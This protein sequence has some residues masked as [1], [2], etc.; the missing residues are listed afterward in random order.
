MKNNYYAVEFS[1]VVTPE[2][3][4][5]RL[6]VTL[7]YIGLP[8]KISRKMTES[9]IINAVELYHHDLDYDMSGAKVQEWF[10]RQV[11]KAACVYIKDPH[12]N[13]VVLTTRRSDGTKPLTFG[14]PGGKV[15]PGE[16]PLQA[17]LR[18]TLEETGIRLREQDVREVFTQ[19]CE[20]EVDYETTTF[21]T[22]YEGAIPGGSEVGIQA[23]WGSNAD[24]LDSRNPFT[25]YNTALLEAL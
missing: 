18:E 6:Y 19:V 8:A 15:D 25:P 7:E 2:G 1:N 14:L 3:Y 16:T 24:L 21:Y 12:T 4:T 9:E 13:E 23:I 5:C 22:E 17:A 11:K 10:V 20:G